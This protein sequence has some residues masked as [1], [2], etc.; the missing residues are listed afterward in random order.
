MKIKIFTLIGTMFAL[1]A[2]AQHEEQV[3]DTILFTNQYGVVVDRHPLEPEARNGI[4]TIESKDHNGTYKLWLDNRVYFDGGYFFD[5]NALNAIGNGLTIRRARM[6]IKTI[7]YKNWYGEIDLDFAG[8]ELEMKDMII[9]YVS[10]T[11]EGLFRKFRVKAGNFKEGLSMET[12]TTS[13][14][15]TFIERSL[16]SKLTPSR[17]L[18]LQ[19]TR[20]ENHWLAIAGIHFQPVGELEENT[21]SKDHNKDDGMDEGYSLTFRGVILPVRTKKSILHIGAGY[22]YRTPKTTWEYPNTFRYST[23]SIS[24]INRKKYLD[25]DDI[26]NIDNI[27]IFNL[28]LAGAYN[29]FMFQAEYTTNTIAGT[30]VNNVAGISSG[31]LEGA[32]AQAAVL[33]FGGHYQYNNAEG[34]FTQVNRG[35]SWGD[36]ELAFRYDYINMNDLD[37]H[38]YGGAANAMTFGINYHVNTNV[39]F[40]LNYTMIDH[41][42][43]AN[44]KGKLYVGHDAYGNLTKDFN[45]VVEETGKGGDDFGMIQARIEI[46]F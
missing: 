24:S 45:E 7:L 20:Y 27:S 6:A 36:I 40:M 25:T 41:D 10:R 5:Q 42:R 21:I 26:G 28:E 16:R 17:H 30:D 32:Y 19:F 35:R 15:V 3:Q 18:G 23:R 12:T 37:A 1:F 33:L 38:I 9:G 4:L 13:R 31:K 44:G 43:Y 22:S 46:D 8:A 2:S 11:N 14:Y 39:K 29:N 34:E